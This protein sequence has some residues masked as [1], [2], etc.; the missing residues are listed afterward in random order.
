MFEDQ[1]TI[2]SSASVIC[3]TNYTGV[4]EKFEGFTPAIVDW[5]SW[6]IFL[7]VSYKFYVFI[8]L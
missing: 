2:A 6:A 5:H 3:C 7:D 1:L 8:L 4:S